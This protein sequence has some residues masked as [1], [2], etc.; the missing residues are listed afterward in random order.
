MT[1]NWQ[2]LLLDW[3]HLT[4]V[5]ISGENALEM[6]DILRI[7]TSALVKIRFVRLNAMNPCCVR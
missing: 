5:N 7:A 3:Q 2:H 4:V 6:N 1:M